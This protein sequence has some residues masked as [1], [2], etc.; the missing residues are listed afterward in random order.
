MDVEVLIPWCKDI[1]ESLLVLRCSCPRRM[2]CW[3]GDH[4]EERLRVGLVVQEAQ[5][6]ISLR[7]TKICHLLPYPTVQDLR[8][9]CIQGV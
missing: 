5:G 4:H 8:E 1:L 6:D 9:A 7:Y 3:C 2:R